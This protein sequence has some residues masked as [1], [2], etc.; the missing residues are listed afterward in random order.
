VSTIFGPRQS[1]RVGRVS[2]EKRSRSTAIESD[3]YAG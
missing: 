2:I 3:R 1:D